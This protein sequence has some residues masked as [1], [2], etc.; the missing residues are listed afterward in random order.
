MLLLPRV[1]CRLAASRLQARQTAAAK[2]F[3]P[4]R[5]EAGS[6]RGFFFNRKPQ[7]QL[8]EIEGL[9]SARDFP[10]LAAEAVQEARQELLGAEKRPALEL[11]QALD[12]V[13]NSLCRVADAA[14]LVRNVHPDQEYVAR[15]SEA[16]QEVAG[17]MGEVNLD[18]A[19][20]QGMKAAESSA[21]FDDMSREARSVL[22]HMRV[23]MEH[24][25][26]HL[27]EAEKAECLQLLEQEQQLS[28]DI[29]RRQGQ[30]HHASS[31]KAQPEGVWVS[32]AACAGALG[33]DASRLPKR[34]AG[35]AEE[36]CLPTD[37]VWSDRILKTVPC[38]ETRK[39][40][41]DAQQVHDQQG[42]EEM[43]GLLC[44]RQ[45]LAQLRGY[46][47]WAHYAQREALFQSPGHVNQ[48]L[49]STWEQLR[50]GLAAELKTLAAEKEK[51]GLGE[52]RLEAWDMPFLIRSCKQ[53]SDQN[54]QISQYLSYSGLMK[55][56]EL[57]LSRLL[58]LGFTQEEPK[59]GELWHPSVQKYAIRDGERILGILYLDPFQRPGKM[60]Q[61]AQFTLQ[62]S[63]LLSDGSQQTPKTSLVYSL[64]VGATGLPL[65][66]AI[67]FM[68]EIGHAVHSLLSE[69]TFQHLS[70]TRGT[71]DFVE[72]PS[73]LFE[74]FVLD[75]DSLASYATHMKSG[76]A[77]PPEVRELC[78]HSRRHFAHFEAS[79]Q[80]L[81]AAV[82]QA[83]YACRPSAQ[84]GS[85]E[86]AA[87]V[88]SHLRQTLSRCDHELD[89]PYNGNLLSLLGLSQPS[90]F[91]HLVHYGG[92][93]Y[94]YLFNRA[95]AAH[96]WQHGFKSDPFGSEAGERLRHMFRGGS[97]VQ[98]L[99]V[100]CSLCPGVPTFEAHE[101]P[102]GGLMQQIG[103]A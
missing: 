103:G 65:S 70:G 75:A 92:S 16:V 58:G 64:P 68:H 96:V 71:V 95:L 31:S 13:S 21:E 66:F 61:S 76:A 73:H 11:V 85:S 102:L 39:R 93:Y 6:K 59:I 28:F 43:A 57:M 37:S 50:P 20:Y 22:H 8:L 78:R 38:S 98:N 100:I 77:M 84:G 99:D 55:G 41:H 86:A 54:D 26:I 25:G 69:T 17:Y 33:A 90:K 87:E 74:H 42:E 7:G 29:V 72:F 46:E 83:F 56:V 14:E 79:Q 44:V 18:A 80:L 47:S 45:R 101:V 10:R 15:A 49:D 30:L 60:V 89:A 40:L 36:V 63:K 62:G 51:L 1:P 4:L 3:L 52:A 53:Q 12:G 81:Y 34:G 9:E 91:D 2:E 23:S 27:P 94:C 67:T 24:E 5:K 19:M 82:D 88:Q 48:F 97:V 35:S 32:L